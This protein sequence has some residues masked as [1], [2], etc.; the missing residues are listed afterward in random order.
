MARYTVTRGTTGTGGVTLNEGDVVELDPH[1]AWVLRHD[2]QI[3]PDP[4]AEP[5]PIPEPP[6]ADEEP[7]PEQKA[8]KKNK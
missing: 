3:I 7:E 5:E 2:L 6:V 8:T 1:T 4:V